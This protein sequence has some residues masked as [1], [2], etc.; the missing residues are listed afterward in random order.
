MHYDPVQAR[1]A[2]AFESALNRLRLVRSVAEVEKGW[3]PE[4]HTGV[5]LAGEKF[6]ADG[7]LPEMQKDYHERVRAA[8][9]EG[10]GFARSCKEHK[11]PWLVFRGVSD[12][13]EKK[14]R[15]GWKLIAALSAATAVH[16][17]IAHDYRPI[18]G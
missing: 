13:G 1:W 18:D 17:F 8:D 10:T 3:K 6:L 16:A 4:Y 14:R 5:I 15:K 9:M 2:D 7:S 11:K 12:F